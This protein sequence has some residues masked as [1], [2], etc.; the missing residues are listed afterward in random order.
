MASETKGIR[1]AIDVSTSCMTSSASKR[2]C[3]GKT[4]RWYPKSV[5]APSQI[6][7]A[8]LAQGI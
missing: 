4:D 5:V 6:A 7:W 2:C 1:I 8:T 3:T